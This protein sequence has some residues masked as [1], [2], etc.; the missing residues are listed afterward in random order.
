MVINTAE[1]LID[2]SDLTRE[3]AL[4]SFPSFLSYVFVLDPPPGGGILKFQPWPH[5][6]DLAGL[7]LS[8]RLLTLVKSRQIGASWL[9]AAYALWTVLRNTGA[10]VAIIS[11]GETEAV[12]FLAKVKFI[13]DMLPDWLKAKDAK[14]NTTEM[15]FPSLYG[16]V[17]AYPS[18]EDAGRSATGTLVVMDEADFHPY[19]AANYAA[20]KPSIDAGG[21]LVMISTPNKRNMVSLFKTLA[22]NAGDRVQG[23]NGWARVFYGWS[24]RPGRDQEWYEKRKAEYSALEEAKSGNPFEGEYPSS[25]MEALSP[26]SQLA[27]FDL[28]VLEAMRLD[29]VRK[30]IETRGLVQIWHKF[31]PGHR[32]GAFSDPSHGVGG[33]DAVTVIGDYATG[34]IVADIQSPLV[35]PEELGM[36][37]TKL[38][39]AYGN[40]IWGIED[41]DWGIVTI[42][43]ALV[44]GYKNLYYRDE[45]KNK[46]GWHTDERTRWELWGECIEAIKARHIVVSSERGLAQFF[47]VIRNPDKGGRI[48]GMVG[49]HDDYPLAV[50]GWWQM[51]KHARLPA[52]GN[53]QVAKWPRT[54]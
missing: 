7:L 42:K 3:L 28:T 8:Q 41:N 49:A 19:L 35:A 16:S 1:R 14:A 44:S 34:S 27:A 24:V 36:E 37:S 15:R 47:S 50:S 33:D 46:P 52:L 22:R 21:Q 48:E 6:L 10:V 30:P 51:R 25:L 13:H 2:R 31:V 39:A 32:Y 45:A 17:T 26:S 12:Q 43:T 4:K 40:P 11:K 20:I 5:L 38:L 53:Q 9:V 23:S 54:A 18:T 29:E